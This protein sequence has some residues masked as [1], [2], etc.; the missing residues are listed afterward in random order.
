MDFSTKRRMEQ[1][2]FKIDVQDKVAIVTGGAQGMG[3]TFVEAF[4]S[5][6]AQVAIADIQ[7]TPELEGPQN[8][9]GRTLAIPTDITDPPSVQK[10]VQEVLKA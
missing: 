2:N 4:L 6:G 5:C 3:R 10:M 1:I 7:V 9:K 8:S